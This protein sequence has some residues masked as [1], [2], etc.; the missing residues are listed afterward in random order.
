M[1]IIGHRGAAGLV[2]ENTI[3]SILK[4]ASL[5][6]SYIEIDVWV[7]SDGHVVVFHDEYLDRLSSS[8]GFISSYSYEEL[9][10]VELN[11]NF[12]IPTLQEVVSVLKPYDIPLIVELKTAEAL[13]PTLSILKDLITHSKYVIGS[14]YHQCIM[15]LKAENRKVNTAIMFEGVPVDLDIYLRKVN[16]DYVVTALE[17]HDDYLINTVKS[18]DRRLVFYTIN[19]EPEFILAKQA[20][21]YGIVTNYPDKFLG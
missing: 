16:P 4:A 21:P 2:M 12:K 6:V 9:V 19:E 18:Q 15:H 7:T 11:G 14:F 1:E 17:S 5:G 8:N 10:Q 13:G 20:A 3:P